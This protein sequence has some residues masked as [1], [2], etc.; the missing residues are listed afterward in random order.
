MQIAL[1]R[2][3]SCPIL[4]AGRL[5]QTLN[6]GGQMCSL[7]LMLYVHQWD[8]EKV[9]RLSESS[10]LCQIRM[11]TKVPFRGSCYGPTVR[12]FSWVTKFEEMAGREVGWILGN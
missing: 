9:H 1:L 6:A 2:R 7:V 8:K 10:S 11:E 12:E 4:N 3:L 5:P